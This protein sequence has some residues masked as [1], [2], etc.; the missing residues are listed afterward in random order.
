MTSRT[1]PTV[2]R[3]LQNAYRFHFANA[4]YTKGRRA[5]GALDLARAEREAC[6][7]GWD[8]EWPFDEDHD[9]GPRDWGWPEKDVKRWEE[10]EHEVLC[11]TLM[12]EEGEG[13]AALYGIWDA[14]RN[15]ARVI[16]AELAL[17]ALGKE[18]RNTP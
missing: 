12:D 10:T 16:E 11:C 2:N 14:N 3:D 4:G 6:A 1:R 15:Y 13:L 7:R 17:E 5:E 8:Y 9:R 18:R